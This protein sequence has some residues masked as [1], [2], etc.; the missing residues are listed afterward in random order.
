MY[1]M[2]FVSQAPNRIFKFQHEKCLQYSML[3]QNLLAISNKNIQRLQHLITQLPMLGLVYL[4]LVLVFFYISQQNV[5][6]PHFLPVQQKFHEEY[7]HSQSQ[8]EFFQQF[9]VAQDQQ[10]GQLI[11][12]ILSMFFHHE[13]IPSVSCPTPQ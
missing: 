1:L 13:A 10:T 5:N 9:C 7:H 6:I 12:N 4:L 2:I 8:R 3:F 11:S